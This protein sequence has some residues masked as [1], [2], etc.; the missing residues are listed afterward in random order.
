VNIAIGIV[1]LFAS[2]G[3]Q[4]DCLAL[5][6]I[7]RARG[8]QVR[9]FTA[10]CDLPD[11]DRDVVLLP[12]RGLTNHG[13]DLSFARA[14]RAAT[15]RGFDLVL[16]CNMLLGLDVL[17]CADRLV[18]ARGLPAWRRWLP[19]YRSRLALERACF[20]AESTTRGLVLSHAA[21]EAARVQWQT[22]DA[23]LTVL[24]PTVSA[25]RIRPQ[26]RSG[27]ER[28]RKRAE[29]GLAESD[30]ALL[31]VAAQP[32]TK[33]LDRALAALAVTP[34]ARLLIAGLG[35]DER[36]SAPYARQ[37]ARLGVAARVDWLGMREDI[38]ELMAA[39]DLLVHPA[40]YDTTGQVI[41][42]AVANGLPVIA[43]AACGFAEHVAAADAGL[44]LPEPFEAGDLAAALRRA[45]PRSQR[46]AWSRNALQ[47]AS[48]RN[49]TS[50]LAHAA[51]LVERIAAA[52][53]SGARP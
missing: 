44:V 46:D 22:P 3:L 14:F 30:L 9:L 23:R 5:H 32:K 37:A 47:Y 7:L 21:A 52:R 34:D 18:G 45:R 53:P 24:P 36:K 41:L 40:R 8:H 1:R 25:G 31:W 17:Y 33:G 16:G 10:R 38:P 35:A 15:R 29:L 49:F 20:S 26:L 48:G 13:R 50:G 2:G 4:R 27:V 39:A 12:A 51:D 6:D 19:R 43:T 11:G 28:G 42:E